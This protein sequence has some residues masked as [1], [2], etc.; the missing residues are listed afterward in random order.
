M[1][2]ESPSS[3]FFR[4]SNVFDIDLIQKQQFIHSKLLHFSVAAVDTCRYLDAK[5]LAEKPY[6][7][8]H[9]ENVSLEYRMLFQ[10]FQKVKVESFSA[11]TFS[12][13]MMMPP[14]TVDIRFNFDRLTL[15]H[16][17]KMGTCYGPATK[18]M[19]DDSMK[20]GTMTLTKYTVNSL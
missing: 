11:G 10:P 2:Y 7:A 15:L 17:K 13:T 3:N 4:R 18:I 5:C 9:D 20:E 6:L 8:L 1:Q 16:P 12:Q 14:T 19:H